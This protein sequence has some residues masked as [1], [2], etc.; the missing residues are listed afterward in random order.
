MPLFTISIVNEKFSS[1]TESEC[2]DAEAA[3]RHAIAAAIAIGSE[4]V[5]AGK[6]FF[7]ALITVE[8][9]VEVLCRFVVSLGASPLNVDEGAG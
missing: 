4:E 1:S 8:Q 7:G 6:P 3:R 5:A 2:P 9:D